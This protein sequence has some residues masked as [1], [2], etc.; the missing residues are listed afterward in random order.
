MGAGASPFGVVAHS[1]EEA[2]VPGDR[3]H[4]GEASS[5]AADESCR[6]KRPCGLAEALGAEVAPKQVVVPPAAPAFDAEARPLAT[7]AAAVRA[8]V[9]C[10]AA[11]AAEAQH[12]ATLRRGPGK[13]APLGEPV[14]APG[15][16]STVILVVLFEP[17]LAM[18]FGV[19]MVVSS[20]A[21]S[22]HVLRQGLV[23][24]LAVGTDDIVVEA[25]Q[26]VN[27]RDG[28]VMCDGVDGHACDAEGF[29]REALV[30]QLP[31]VSVHM[32]VV[33]KRT[34]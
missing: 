32:A 24:M 21:G 22:R 25:A 28:N 17:H 33:A 26:A 6:W 9:A 23:V 15:V 14:L 18:A 1:A 13:L 19:L 34:E 12:S 27:E 16:V 31:A 2:G 20:E 10:R 8:A 3:A 5:Q 30:D 11:E 29:L 7:A 4:R